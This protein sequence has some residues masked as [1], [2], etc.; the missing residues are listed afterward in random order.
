MKV[1]AQIDRNT[2]MC[3]VS[4]DEIALLNGFKTP[5][6]KGCLIDDLMRVGS[7][8]DLKK[9]VTTSQFVRNLRKDVLEKAR[10]QLENTICQIEETMDEVAK[11]ELFDVLKDEEQIG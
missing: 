2:V 1:I 4:R 3:Q 7:E 8:C 9:M 6:D 11:L 5:W 10:V